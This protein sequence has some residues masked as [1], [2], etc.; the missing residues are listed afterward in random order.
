MTRARALR[1]F[2]FLTLVGPFAL[3]LVAQVGFLVHQVAFL[4][5]SIGR[6]Q[7]GIAVAITTIMA[8]V[9]RLAVGP[10]ID[11]LD[12]RQVSAATFA[13]QSVAL[14]GM[15]LTSDT[16]LLLLLCCIFGFSAGN[17]LTLPQ[18][19]LQREFSPAAFGML[20]TLASAIVT[21]AAAIGPGL[22]GIVRDATDSY[23]AG[24]LM[25]A[26]LEALAAVV[27]LMRPT[28]RNS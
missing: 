10:F 28:T 23:A 25:S 24:L 6:T 17:L 21:L 22:V 1:D 16:T 11:R 13:S 2:G 19:T 20:V 14:V 12:P 18:I 15:T 8:V 5:S 26:G 3:A 9:G 27:V 7:A 4:Q